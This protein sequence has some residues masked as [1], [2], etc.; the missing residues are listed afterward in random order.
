MTTRILP[1]EEWPRLAATDFGPI[2]DRLN[3][4]AVTIVVAEHQGAIVGCWGLITFAHVEGLW[5]APAYRRR[6][7]RVLVR[8][9]NAMRELAM[10]RHIDVVYT[11]A[12]RGDVQRLLASR[13]AEA[14]P[15]MYAL[16]LA[17]LGR[18]R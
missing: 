1:P 10:G 11:G 6:G 4:E 7:G 9:W 17:P 12:L 8:L 3:R 5:V 15:P 16:P 14:L 13:Q 2:L 18:V